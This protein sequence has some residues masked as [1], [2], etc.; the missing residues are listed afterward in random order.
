MVVV[1]PEKIEWQRVE[2][3]PKGAWAKLLSLDE[4]I[5]A[6]TMLVKLDKGFHEPKHTHPS[7][8]HVMVLQGRLVDGKMGEIKK[9]M[10]WF[11]PAGEEHGPEDAPEGCLLF[12]HLCGPAW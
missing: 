5:R 11:I 7:D 9:G 8:A 2:Q 12:V 4:E 6:M 3:L 1:D 10:Y